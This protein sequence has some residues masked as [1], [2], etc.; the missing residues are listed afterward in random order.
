MCRIPVKFIVN[1]F[2]FFM[3]SM[4]VPQLIIYEIVR[5]PSIHRSIRPSFRP[6]IPTNRH[7][8]ATL[9]YCKLKDFK[10]KLRN[11]SL[12][13]IKGANKLKMR[14]ISVKIEGG[15]LGTFCFVGYFF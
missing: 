1:L 6:S 14:F 3:F 5:Y 7:V 12:L 10:N 11:K 2:R 13:H 9:N 4:Q 15:L 8:L